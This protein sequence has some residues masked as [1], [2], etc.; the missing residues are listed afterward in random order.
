[1]Q[2]RSTFYRLSAL[3]TLALLLC[4]LPG[5][6][7]PNVQRQALYV[8]CG[9]GQSVVLYHIDPRTGLLEEKQRTEL[10]GRAGPIALAPDGG[11]IYAALNNPPRLLPMTRDRHSGE[12]ELLEPTAVPSFPAYLDID[13]TGRFALAA[14]YA[15][16]Q[17]F[18]MKLQKDRTVAENPL[19]TFNTEKNSHACLIDPSNRFVYVPHTGPN[20]IYQFRFDEGFLRPLQPLVVAGGGGP[21]TP[22]GPRHYVYH[23]H[24]RLGVL[25]TVNELNSTVSAYQWDRITGQLARFQNLSTLP[26]NFSGKNTTADIHITPNGRFLYASNRGHNSIA[27]YKLDKDGQMTFIDCFPT[28]PVPRE[29]AIDLNGRFLYAAGLNSSKLAAYAI[30]PLTGRLTRIATYDTPQA[31]IWVEPAA[32]D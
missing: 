21:D 16:G 17:V 25:Y 23:P 26:E 10:P 3:F 15:E 28:E 6:K 18:S 8:S 27:A 24:P 7:S 19:Q 11:A 4:V 9:G 14:C 32:L 31:P 1:M 5:C 2:K 30:D 29:F 22:A 12:L 13:A 20:A